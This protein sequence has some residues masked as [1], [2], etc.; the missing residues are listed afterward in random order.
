MSALT[1][2]SFNSVG[3]DIGTTTTSVIF[4]KITLKN[5]SLNEASKIEIVEKETIYKSPIYFTPFTD[6]TTIDYLKL[7][8]IIAKEYIKTNIPKEEVATG[9]I[10]ITGESAGKDNAKEV[11]ATLSEFAGDFVVATAGADL[12]ARL[13]GFGSGAEELSKEFG[14]VIN[15]DIGGGTTNICCFNYG[16][17]LDCFALNIGGRLLSFDDNGLIKYIAPSLK[18]LILEKALIISIGERPTYEKLKGI[19]DIYAEMLLEVSGV[20][21][22]KAE[23]KEL[24]I[25]HENKGLKGDY[26]VFSGGVAEFIYSEEEIDT[27]EKVQQYNDIGPL[28][29]YSIKN[30]LLGLKV[31]LL[32]PKEKIRATVIGAGS[33][34]LKVSGSTITYDEKLLPIKNI[35]IIKTTLFDKKG[36]YDKSELLG[37]REEINMY[38]GSQVALAFRG[39]KGP[40]YKE[41]TEIAEAIIFIFKASF[42]PIILII[43]E[44]LGKALGQTLRLK[45]SGATALICLDRIFLS[46]EDYIDIGRPL[47]RAIPVVKK[48]LIF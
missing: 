21:K 37:L 16:E 11:V 25:A 17:I 43:E 40:S 3:I 38:K 48:T 10:I 30:A 19:T 28:L 36:H 22:L 45:L 41:I 42:M 47:G 7:K 14:S 2:T 12:E 33:H 5:P 4:S 18:K 23:T 9:A 44:D 26:L 6:S 31:G 32:S 13:A 27:L 35:P 34:S 46:K 39:I 8:D 15:L 24:F 29:G 20:R 1:F